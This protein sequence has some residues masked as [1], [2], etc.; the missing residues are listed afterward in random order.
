[1]LACLLFRCNTIHHVGVAHEKLKQFIGAERFE[2]LYGKKQAA[3][4]GGA[5]GEEK[6]KKA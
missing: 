5:G 2:D 4:K 6:E 1:M 3:G